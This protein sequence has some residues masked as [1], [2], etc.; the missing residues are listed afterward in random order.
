VRES[1]PTRSYIAGDLAN[2]SDTL[3]AWIRHRY[4]F[5]QV[6]AMPEMGLG[7]Q[8]ARD[9]G[10]YLYAARGGERALNIRADGHL[11]RRCA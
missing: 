6:T 4:R 8:E 5:N 3:V 2:N 9:R 10:A 11:P 7:E 1:R